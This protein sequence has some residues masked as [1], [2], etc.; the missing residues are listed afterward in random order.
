MST[1]P[2]ALPVADIISVT[3]TAPTGA[4]APRQFN[5][6]LIVG[7]SPVIPSYG[8]N[9]R[10]RQYASL[11]A[12]L[13]DGFTS[14][15]PE[16][17][18]ASLYFGQNVPPEFVWIGRQ[19]LTAISAV[20]PHTGALGTGY[21]VGDTVTPTQGGASNA[22]LTVLTIGAGG[23]VTSLGTTVGNQG[24]GYSI[25]T[26]LPTTT[27]GSGTGLFVDISAIGETLLQAVQACALVN[28]QWYG[29]MCTGATDS[30]HLALAA[31]STAN[32]LS[33][34]YIGSSSDVAIENGTTGNLA[35]QMQTLKDK[36]MLIYATTQGGA[37]PNNI[38]AAAAVLGLYCGLDTG[39]PGSAFTLNLKSLAGI[40]PEPL[41]QSQYAAITG[42]NCNVSASFG[43]YT[44]YLTPGI[45]SS[46]DF[47]DQILNRATLVNLIQTNLMNL[48]IT[49]PKI[50]QTDAGEHQ[51]IAQVDQ[52]CGQM[53]AIGY[54]APGIWTGGPIDDLLGNVLI[55][56]N[57][58]LPRGF[59]TV[60]APFSQQSAGNRAAR[61]AMPLSCA[62]IEAGAVH[63]VQIQISTQL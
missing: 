4:V 21:A 31:Y 52:A 10:L 59:S 19:D 35:L 40:T 13:T 18:A 36:A 22:K 38:Y 33:L 17:I 12:M 27:S 61:Q 44:G 50:P 57:E 9:P 51:L 48:L 24:T 46:G 11:A 47:F 15:E 60:A 30:D 56:T 8:A 6:G 14:S 2:L 23:S 54:L 43:P 37:F 28:Q 39:L 45:L 3:V 32:F 25:A 58:P 53:V 63:S 34:L 1:R 41:T 20:N 49:S 62:I 7:S 42:A 26:D 16:Y 29:F 55:A 5:Q